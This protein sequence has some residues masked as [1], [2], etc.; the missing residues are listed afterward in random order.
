MRSS[1]DKMKNTK[2]PRAEG[3]DCQ[4]MILA[5]GEVTEWRATGRALPMSGKIAFAEFHDLTPELLEE[6][7]P[8]I[9]LS[10]VLCASFDCLDLAQT[11]TSFE[12]SGR[13]RVLAADVPNPSMVKR[14]IAAC[15]PTLNFEMLDVVDHTPATLN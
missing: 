14:E 15:C 5:V 10:P 13:Y 1:L 2:R 7:R 11:L 8:D 6:L 9:V 4:P 12:Y 3:D